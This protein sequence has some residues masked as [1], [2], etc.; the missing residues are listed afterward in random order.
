MKVKGL[1]LITIILL[2]AV[3]HSA[4][5]VG[6]RAP[7]F[8]LQDTAGNWYNLSDYRG[9]VVHLDFWQASCITCRQELPWVQ[10]MYDTYGALGYQPLAI[11]VAEPLDSVKAFARQHNFPVLW[12]S[13]M[14]VFMLYQG[15]MFL[16]VNCVIC[17]SGI[18][19]YWSERTLDSIAIRDTVLAWLP[20]AVDAAVLQIMSPSAVVDS[21]SVVTPACSVYNCGTSTISYQ[22]RMKIG[23]QYD[24][25][26][27]VDNHLPNTVRYVTFPDWVAGPQGSLAISCSTEAAGDGHPANDRLMG[28]VTVNPPVVDVG[29]FRILAPRG[30]LDSGAVRVPACSVINY[31]PFPASYQVTMK[32]G[33]DYHSTVPVNDHL[34]G[35]SRYLTFPSWIATVV[36]TIPVRC[37]TAGANDTIPEN[38]LC[39]DS[40]IVN[41]APQYQPGWHSSAGVPAGPKGKGI[42]DGGCLTAWQLNDTNHVF[43][44]KGN[45]TCEF[46]HYNA[47][48]ESWTTM[49]SIPAIGQ[50]GK[51]KRVKKGA[52]LAKDLRAASGITTFATK[53]N[54]T[55]EFWEY[56]GFWQ[57][58]PDVPAGAKPVKDGASMTFVTAGDSG[59]CY[60]LKGSGTQEFYRFNIAANSWE[61]RSPAPLGITGRPFKKG[62]CI[63]Y[64]YDRH[65]IYAL[66]GS[67]KV[68]EFF[69]YDCAADNWSSLKEMPLV[70][71]SGKKKKL[72]DGA[73]LVYAQGR[74]YALKGSN[75]LEFWCYDPSTDAWN[76]LTDVP[77]G[78]GKGVKSGGGIAAARALTPTDA[79]TTLYI[80]KGNGTWEFLSYV[81]DTLLPS[82]PNIAGKVT[83]ECAARLT[84]IPS[85]LTDRATVNYSLS[86]AG[87]VALRLYDAGGRLVM[88]LTSGYREAGTHR[89]QL[90]GDR[91]NRG[92]YLLRLEGAA[93]T[94]TA[95]LIIE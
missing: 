27:Q 8:A 16:P 53:G 38:D 87:E 35:T 40:V 66:K 33:A 23:S 92:L 1:L 58:R 48:S 51:K 78:G 28:T 31:G 20:T 10:R 4:P 75:T 32:I 57:Q 94:A 26:V 7:G 50:S 82:P 68:N 52:T 6:E 64:D 84:V 11:N 74:V 80:I 12:D 2:P 71:R 44:L 72:G 86:Q 65:R 36:G 24:A 5:A 89:L 62:S 18:V 67:A 76:Q 13:L 63:T 59:Y 69:A 15:H 9:K 49:E 81:P 3:L 93:A 21:G 85:L 79:W 42:K 60:L 54:S 39:R 19:R 56:S 34:P 43:L 45:N 17:P 95:K 83:S 73:G 55:L 91:L 46:Y 61:T 90:T 47:R 22:V 70:G 77:L 37:S 25:A 88:T 30:S 29:C 14:E 41:P